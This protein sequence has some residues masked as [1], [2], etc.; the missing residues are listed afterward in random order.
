MLDRED[1]KN[2]LNRVMQGLGSEHGGTNDAG[3]L[4]GMG[5]RAFANDDGSVGGGGGGG[6]Q[7]KLSKVRREL[8]ARKKRS[9]IIILI[10]GC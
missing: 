4:S 5:G 10:L 8:F 3:S 6:S 7:S 1:Q 9:A 2:A